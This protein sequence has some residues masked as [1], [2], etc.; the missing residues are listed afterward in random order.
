MLVEQN[1]WAMVIGADLP[2][3][4]VYSDGTVL[5]ADPNSRKEPTY[6]VSQIR[7]NE[8][9]RLLQ[10]IG[11]TPAFDVLKENYS[12][13]GPT[14]RPTTAVV[15]FGKGGRRSVSVYGYSTAPQDTR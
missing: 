11:P 3:V 15:L 14:D 1:P 4:V 7:G 2:S 12:M 9:N 13:S 6:L 5:R 8:W 10:S